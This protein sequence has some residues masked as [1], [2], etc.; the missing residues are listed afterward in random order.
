MPL[1]EGEQL[2]RLLLLLLLSS[3]RLTAA[4]A[5]GMRG[6]KGREGKQE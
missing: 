3:A 6:G 5:A 4:V 2:L 1:T